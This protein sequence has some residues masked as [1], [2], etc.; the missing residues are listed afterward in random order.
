[1][2]RNISRF[3]ITGT[4]SGCGKTTVTCA[5][6]KALK[7]RGL[8]V[9]S[10]KAGP[11]Y[12]DPMFHSKVIGA[13]ARN[14]DIFLSGE[15]SVKYL[16]A[17]GA[18]NSDISV[19][20]GVMGNYDGIG[21]KDDS[22]SSNHLAKLTGT[23]QVLVLETK[24]MSFSVVAMISG[25]LNF[26][27]NNI[28][29][30]ILNNTS[31]KMYEIL[32]PAIEENLPVKVYGY[33]PKVPGA[34]IES[35]H[36]GLITADE[37]DNIKAKLDLLAETAEKTID[38]DGLLELAKTY[39]YYVCSDALIDYILPKFSTRIAVA[40]DAAFCFK[41]ED[42]LELLRIM[43]AEIIPFSPIKDKCLPENINAV[44]FPGGYPEL[45]AKEL[46]ENQ[47]LRNEIKDKINKGL[48]VIAE[49]GGFMYLQKEYEDKNGMI[50][51][52]VGAIDGKTH[53]TEHL[54]RFGYI[55]MTSQNDNLFFKTGEKINAHEFHYSDSD[56]C[57]NDFEAVKVNGKK[58][59]VMIAD[60]TK[61]IGYP[62]IHLWGNIP[63]ATNFYNN[64]KDK[65]F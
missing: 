29:G 23:P 2:T 60:S 6:L 30:V 64:I 14:L 5:I 42:N 47:N 36:L 51:E 49:C 9:T 7:K 39:N 4:G 40:D 21:I 11:D 22:Y 15:K 31:E 33:M 17:K 44:I 12:I 43:G 61:F 16:L 52:M 58:W 62:H 18:E 56:N 38:I 13:K 63:C 35:R 8:K 20:E 55:T 48:P 34:A 10:F 28:K 26:R 19:I 65:T 41:Y 37:I 50:Y 24:G 32:K 45:Y 46:S 1:M 59:P 53:M 54:V 25:Y 27:Q 57:G 3:M